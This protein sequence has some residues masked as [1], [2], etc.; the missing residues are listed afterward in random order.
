MLKLK[1]RHVEYLVITAIEVVVWATLST[2][3]DNVITAIEVVVRATSSTASD[4]VI[5]AIEVAVRVT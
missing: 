3:N 1:R 5:T 4:N 2:A